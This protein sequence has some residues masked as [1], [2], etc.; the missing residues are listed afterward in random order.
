MLPAFQEEAF[1]STNLIINVNQEAEGR[2]LLIL[3][4]SCESRLFLAAILCVE[5]LQMISFR[6]RN[7]SME[8]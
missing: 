2:M 7:S 8:V 4:F 5:K 3:Q 6:R 1:I